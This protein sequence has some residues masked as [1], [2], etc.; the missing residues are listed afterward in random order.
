MQ[1]ICMKL[2][3]FNEYLISTVDADGISSHSA[4]YALVCFLAF[5]VQ[6]IVNFLQFTHSSDSI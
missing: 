2:A 6:K 3:Q 1:Y 4:E 5:K